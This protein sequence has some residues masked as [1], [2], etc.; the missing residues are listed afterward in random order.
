MTKLYFSSKRRDE[1]TEEAEQPG[2]GSAKEEAV[3]ESAEVDV[4]RDLPPVKVGEISLDDEDL[5]ARVSVFA[6]VGKL[7]ARD[8]EGE[9]LLEKLK[10]SSGDEARALLEGRLQK[11]Y[12]LLNRALSTL[13]GQPDLLASVLEVVLGE[14][15]E[16]VEKAVEPIGKAV[17][18]VARETTEATMGH[19]DSRAH[20]MRNG[21]ENVA[22]KCAAQARRAAWTAR[23]AVRTRREAKAARDAVADEN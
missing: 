19:R 13:D 20:R 15:A 12:A 11:V 16:G 17:S 8:D 3:S 7:D 2:D 21:I 10:G 6:K 23:Q 5:R 22:R 18:D 14:E 4:L 1:P 9:A